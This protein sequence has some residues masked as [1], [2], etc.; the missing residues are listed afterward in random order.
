MAD[1]RLERLLRHGDDDVDTFVSPLAGETYALDTWAAA[2][3]SLEDR[4][5]RE[6]RLKQRRLQQ[7]QQQQ[8]A[9]SGSGV[10]GSSAAAATLMSSGAT[11]SFAV[12]A[13]PSSLS[14]KA[15]P[16]VN[17]SSPVKAGRI[18]GP[19]PAAAAVQ[20]SGGGARV[21]RP[22]SSHHEQ[23]RPH[24]P[25]DSNILYKIDVPID[26]DDDDPPIL[27]CAE[28]AILKARKPSEWA[29][30]T[31]RGMHNLIADYAPSSQTL[32]T[33]GTATPTTIAA[34]V[35]EDASYMCTTSLDSGGGG[36]GKNEAIRQLL[37]A[38]ASDAVRSSVSG[39]PH[40][41]QL[42]SDIPASG[43]SFLKAL[44]REVA[45]V[46]GSG[47]ALYG[48]VGLAS[49]QQQHHSAV[50]TI[51]S[52][53]NDYY[54]SEIAAVHHSRRRARRLL[55]GDDSGAHGG[56]MSA[57]NGQSGGDSLAIALQSPSGD[58]GTF[59]PSHVLSTGGGGVSDEPITIK[60]IL[61]KAAAAAAAD[62]SP[63]TTAG[64]F[65]SY[66]E[67]L[68]SAIGSFSSPSSQSRS[69]ASRGGGRDEKGTQQKGPSA[70]GSLYALRTSAY[71]T[72]AGEVNEDDG[73]RDATNAATHQGGK[74]GTPML[75][76]GGGGGRMSVDALFDALSTQDGN[77][78][79]K[80]VAGGGGGGGGGRVRLTDSTLGMAMLSLP[81]LASGAG[82]PPTPTGGGTCAS[83]APR[84]G[85]SRALEPLAVGRSPSSPA[86]L[87]ATY[88]GSRGPPRIGSAGGASV[89]GSSTTATSAAAHGSMRATAQRFRQHGAMAGIVGATVA[90]PALASR[91]PTRAEDERLM[92]EVAAVN[93]PER[94][95]ELA[96]LRDQQAIR[97]EI[98]EGFRR[99]YDN[100]VAYVTAVMSGMAE[101]NFSTTLHDPALL[102]PTHSHKVL[103]L[104]S[105]LRRETVP[106]M[107]VEHAPE[108]D[109]SS[110]GGT[111]SD[112]EEDEM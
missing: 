1:G 51:A 72:S 41:T 64:R 77:N 108:G 105:R 9:G 27:L 107:F 53:Q 110:D 89:N 98:F 12:A 96:V 82:R 31:R 16:T 71:L 45:A 34:A 92:A 65:P 86:A 50:A 55:E 3:S 100:H 15:S 43:K 67:A 88:G 106:I 48:D 79:R 26:P 21:Q 90:A 87:A 66:A 91:E 73:D 83:G 85:A 109:S 63:S 68:R 13:S 76:S 54:P 74:G 20:Q 4:R 5:L 11:V 42:H 33:S 56:S 36:G 81:P 44:I 29:R 99:D 37:L 47:E 102:V 7:Q 49:R 70:I 101:G 75:R 62:A 78:T 57:A 61:A 22:A 30:P 112:D 95:R 23:Q 69:P 17:A 32:R 28:S 8:Q 97:A 59:S 24:S 104:M 6:R 46:E 52:P 25:A 18:G 2:T 10:G 93:Y 38:D 103:Q 58:D 60:S 94:Y 14:A 40:R 111:S 84:G 80:S 35:G 39:A 19:T